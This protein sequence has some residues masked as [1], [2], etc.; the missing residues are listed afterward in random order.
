VW[1]PKLQGCSVVGALWSLGFFFDGL[2]KIY[3]EKGANMADSKDIFIPTCIHSF[4]DARILGEMLRSY[5]IHNI[6][7]VRYLEDESSDTRYIIDYI[8]N[9]LTVKFSTD[10][11]AQLCVHPTVLSRTGMTNKA[12]LSTVHMM[13]TILIVYD[14][15]RSTKDKIIELTRSESGMKA[16][17]EAN[18][19]AIA[20]DLSRRIGRILDFKTCMRILT[21][22]IS[23]NCS[24]CQANPV[25]ACAIQAAV[26]DTMLAEEDF[27]NEMLEIE[28]KATEM[29]REAKRRLDERKD[30]AIAMIA[31][32]VGRANASAQLSETAAR[33][34]VNGLC[35][36]IRT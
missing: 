23:E 35:V 5:V 21:A 31:E 2:T 20:H 22:I 13:L 30:Q 32:I 1:W 36:R 25:E 8:M 9:N 14:V 28:R 16:F 29:R 15:F 7:F 10:M 24:G 17:Y 19:N 26:E 3:K 33:H 27:R 34:I 18:K 11:T 6:S 4:D 12:V